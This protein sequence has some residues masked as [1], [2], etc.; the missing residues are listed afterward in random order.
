MY[1]GHFLDTAKDLVEKK[2][3]VSSDGR[4]LNLLFPELLDV[5]RSDDE[6]PPLVRV[7]TCG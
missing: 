6:N 2:N 1:F 5:K 7:G 4:N 3:Q